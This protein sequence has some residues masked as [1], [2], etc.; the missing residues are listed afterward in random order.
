M[1]L[2]G[3]ASVQGMH[4]SKLSETTPWTQ[5]CARIAS[6]SCSRTVLK[7]SDG[8]NDPEESCDAKLAR[9]VEQRTWRVC[10]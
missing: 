4:C 6:W 1:A 9:Y 7:P 3:H 5:T 10:L 2:S 8:S